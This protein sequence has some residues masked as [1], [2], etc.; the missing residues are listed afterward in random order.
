L[1]SLEATELLIFENR[2]LSIAPIEV[3]RPHAH[4]S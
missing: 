3:N 1:E 4:L 2:F